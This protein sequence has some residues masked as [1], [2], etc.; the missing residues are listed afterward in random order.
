MD[1]LSCHRDSSA[2]IMWLESMKLRSCYNW[3]IITPVNDGLWRRRWMEY[4][5]FVWPFID[6]WVMTFDTFPVYAVTC[7]VLVFTDS[8]WLFSL[9]SGVTDVIHHSSFLLSSRMNLQAQFEN[10]N[11]ILLVSNYFK[12]DFISFSSR[13]VGQKRFEN[14]IFDNPN[15]LKLVLYWS[16]FPRQFMFPLPLL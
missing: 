9:L 5:I 6:S 11:E 1:L 12:M 10:A 7:F 13:D 14:K 4:L 3:W 2:V 15:N 16:L 8:W